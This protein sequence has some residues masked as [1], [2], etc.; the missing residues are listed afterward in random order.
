MNPF[1]LSPQ[2][3]SLLA[4]KA[5]RRT[6]IARIL[7]VLAICEISSYFAKLNMQLAMSCPGTSSCL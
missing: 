5:F 2:F 4:C 3:T 1:L 6:G 7:T